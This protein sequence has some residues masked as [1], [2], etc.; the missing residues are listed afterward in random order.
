[1]TDLFETM[2]TAR[3]VRRFRDEPVGDDV[4]ERCL[5]AATWAPSGGNQQSWRF[6]VLRSAQSRAAIAAGAAGALEVIQRVYGLSRPP[7]EDNSRAA[8]SSRA[9]FELHDRAEQVPAAV[10]FT[11]RPQP[12]V[13]RL[14]QGASIFPA[15]QNFLLA[16]RAEGLGALVTG[17]AAAAE[18]LLRASVGVPD[19]W[20]LAALV[21]TGWPCGHHG[22]VRRRPVGDVACVDRWDQPLRTSERV[23]PG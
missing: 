8:R 11:F 6:V 19:D 17:W 23:G 5:T 21:V 4:L 18:D 14:F 1:V 22:P 7:P 2:R 9:V 13:P 3:A 20:Q 15:M 12:A 10:L 16:A